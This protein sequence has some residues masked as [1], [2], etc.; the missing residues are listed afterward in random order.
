MFLTTRIEEVVTY[1]FRFKHLNK[2]LIG[3]TICINQKFLKIPCE[4]YLEVFACSLTHFKELKFA[5]KRLCNL[6]RT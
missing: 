5:I 4:M 2:A 3:K 1:L 6:Y